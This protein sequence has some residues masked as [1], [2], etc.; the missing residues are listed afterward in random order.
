MP[1]TPIAGVTRLRAFQLGLETTAFTQHAATRRMP[2]SFAP[3]VDPHWTFP[4][5]DTGTLDQAIAPYQTATDITGVA[6]GQL[7]SN[8]TPSL[9][10]GAVLGGVTPVNAGGVSTWTYAPSSLTQDDFDTQTGEWFDDAT[11]DAWAGAGG[12]VD[13]FTLTGPQDLGPITLSANW[14][15]GKAIYPATPTGA[16]TVDLN[17]APLFAADTTLYI[18]TGAGSI[19]ISP[20]TDALYDW[21]LTLNNNLDLKRFQNGSNTR[22]QIVNYGRGLRE[23]TATF[24]FAKSTQAIAES[25]KWLTATPTERYVSLDTQSQVLISGSTYHRQRIRFGG[26]WTTRADT[27]INSNT[28]FQLTCHNVYDPTLTYPFQVF[29]TNTRSSL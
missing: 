26:F 19:G 27:T 23:L 3:T 11:A 12:V 10:A 7:Y 1:L 2:W 25:V 8:D 16:L 13:S 18:D 14:R 15:F 21:S 24:N 5:A 29:L 4:T 28:G 9:Y 20:I 22:F 17:P 6:T